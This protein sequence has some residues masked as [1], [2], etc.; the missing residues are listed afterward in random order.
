M[1]LS[2]S[3]NDG[4]HARLSRAHPRLQDLMQ[5]AIKVYPFTM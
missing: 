3:F 5:E 2:Y 4:A 1:S